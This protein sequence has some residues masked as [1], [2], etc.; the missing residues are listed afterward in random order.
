[1][2]QR[3]QKGPKEP[4]VMITKRAFLVVLLALFF[5]GGLSRAD[6]HI[7][8]DPTAFPDPVP[9]GHVMGAVYNDDPFGVLASYDSFG[10]YIGVSPV[11]DS[12]SYGGLTVTSEVDLWSG[13]A[14]A[15]SSSTT[16]SSATGDG[17]INFWVDYAD[18]ISLHWLWDGYAN[19]TSS[20]WSIYL[21]QLTP[22]YIDLG[23]W[24]FTGQPAEN[25]ITLTTLSPGPENTYSLAWLFNVVSDKLPG[26]LGVASFTVDLTDSGTPADYPDIEVLP[27]SYNFGDVALGSSTTT[28][29]NISNTDAT[30]DLQI[31]SLTFF[32]SSAAFSITSAP[33]LPATIGPGGN[34]D[35]EITFEPFDGDPLE[36]AH[37]EILSN[38]PD[39][40][41]VSVLLSGCGVPPVSVPD[42]VVSPIVYDFGNVE[43]SSVQTTNI[44]IS[45]TGSSNL[46]IDSI[47]FSSG[48]SGDF[49]ITSPGPLPGVIA[50]GANV[51]IEI[52]FSPSSVGA[53]HAVLVISSDDP[54]E[55]LIE[56]NL[57][58]ASV[59][60]ILLSP[61][62]YYDFGSVEI[63]SEES[64]TSRITNMGYGDLIVNSI[65][66][67]PESSSSFSITSSPTLPV[68]LKRGEHVGVGIKF[69]PL[70]VDYFEAYWQVGSNDPD[71]P[72]AEATFDGFGVLSL[73]VFL[74][75]ITDPITSKTKWI[76]CHIRPPDGVDVTEINLGTILLE[77]VSP[78]RTS[79][80]LRQQMVV[81]RFS[82]SELALVPST[83]LVLLTVTGELT[84]SIPFEGS[85]YVTVG[86]RSKKK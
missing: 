20:G 24:S 12:L 27:T 19:Y 42:I 43:T 13:T 40:S 22:E 18:P 48:S 30:A 8:Y 85:D 14:Y 83:E 17:Y 56:V 29:I 15:E 76:T 6:V 62:S 60:N 61:S 51:D 45:N 23:S 16:Q 26:N 78:V 55:S 77:G 4:N 64:T 82:A 70:T 7:I 28:N 71:E 50:P 10:Q 35:I 79:V 74:D 75:V 37:L 21:T 34:I 25:T 3:K 47:V 57:D 54:D 32:E 39:E 53:F 66:L 1:M 33:S 86:E 11:S 49:S 58:G 67:S 31:V 65:A 38:D 69:T 80:R 41:L 68:T 73:D 44:N 5:G 63:G 52:T 46:N 81:A 2:L 59:P 36:H 9:Y 72:L 84:D